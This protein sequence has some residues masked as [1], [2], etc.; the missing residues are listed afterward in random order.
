MAGDW[1]AHLIGKALI[2]LNF[3]EQGAEADF[4]YSLVRFRDNMEGVAL[5]RGE[6]DELNGFRSRFGNV[7]STWWA[8]M[9]RQRKLAWFTAGYGQAATIVPFIAAAPRFFSGALPL[10]GLMQTAGAFGYVRDA[11]SWF[12]N[13]YVAFASWKAA[14]DRLTT[15]REA[16]DGAQQNQRSKVGIQVRDGPTADLEF[17]QVKLDSPSGTPLVAVGKLEVSPGSRVFIQGASGSGKSILLRAIA[18]IWPFGHG[19]IRRPDPFDALFLP[20]LA[21]FPLGTLREAMCYPTPCSLF[22]DI[23]LKEALESVDLAHLIPAL[24]RIGQLVADTIRRRS[25]TCCL[26]ASAAATTAMVVSG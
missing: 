7:F 24:G 3:R 22:T 9:R 8:I 5:Y 17:D 23:Q 2:T 26:C 10:G 1:V 6:E 11:L 14:V 12:V 4:R 20:Q 16:I 18:G 25:A 19:S 15:F 21:Y 13:A